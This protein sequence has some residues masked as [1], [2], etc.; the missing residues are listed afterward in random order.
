MREAWIMHQTDRAEAPGLRVQAAED[1]VHMA[2]GLGGAG[3]HGHDVCHY[4]V[5]L[6]ACVHV[7]MCVYLQVYVFGHIHMC[8]H[9][10]IHTYMHAMMCCTICV[11]CMYIMYALSRPLC[12][13]KH[14]LCVCTCVHV[15][16]CTVRGGG[17]DTHAYIVVPWP[18]ATWQGQV[19]G[20]RAHHQGEE[21]WGHDSAQE[22]AL[23][24]GR[25][26]VSTAG[27][28]IPGPAL[29]TAVRL[30]AVVVVRATYDFYFAFAGLF[31]HKTVLTKFHDWVAVNADIL[32]P[33]V[34]SENNHWRSG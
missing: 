34:S 7:R 13:Y 4:S 3:V 27:V 16:P 22:R 25:V 18:G 1:A 17:R 12:V 19:R 30:A 9:A 24:P 33:V 5:C 26:L 11:H 10:H 21:G 2:E 28:C 32:T 31:L 6:H 8:L 15:S 23:R 14:V 20:T 29:C